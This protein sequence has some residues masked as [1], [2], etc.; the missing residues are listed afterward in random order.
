A[1]QASVLGGWLDLPIHCFMNSSSRLPDLRDFHPR[2]HTASR[3]APYSSSYPQTHRFLVP[4][5]LR[6]NWRLPMIRLVRQFMKL[7]VGFILS[8]AHV[9]LAAS[10]TPEFAGSPYSDQNTFSDTWVATDGAGRAVPGYDECGPP[11]RDKWV[12]IFCWTWNVPPA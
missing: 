11:K 6:S 7:A 2:M 5:H 1:E 8:F 4:M 9:A 3:S 12:G 10:F